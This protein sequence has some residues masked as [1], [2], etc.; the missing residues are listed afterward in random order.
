MLSAIITAA[1]RPY[2]LTTP[3]ITMRITF[4]MTKVRWRMPVPQK[5]SPHR[6]R[7]RSGGGYT[8]GRSRHTTPLVC[9]NMSIVSQDF[10][11][12]A[13]YDSSIVVGVE[14]SDSGVITMRKM[15]IRSQSTMLLFLLFFQGHNGIN[16]RNSILSIL[17]LQS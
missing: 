2:L 8:G 3:D 12:V 14:R 5:P 11:D 13:Y 9:V 4:L 17:K 7:Y 1:M 10:C 15:E 16:I 6:C